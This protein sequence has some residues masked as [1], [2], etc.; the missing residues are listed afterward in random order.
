MFVKDETDDEDVCLDPLRCRLMRWVL[1]AA[2]TCLTQQSTSSW[3]AAAKRWCPMCVVHWNTK[4]LD[5]MEVTWEQ[6]RH[7]RRGITR[8]PLSF[9]WL[10]SSS[11]YSSRTWASDLGPYNTNHL[12]FQ[13]CRT[14]AQAD[15]HA[16]CM[17]YRFIR[18]STHTHT[19]RYATAVGKVQTQNATWLHTRRRI[20]NSARPPH[21]H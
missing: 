18:R 5:F 16:N 21:L 6:L 4:G 17:R 20:S 15:T 11:K 8:R 7:S 14:Y 9:S 13:R 10:I 12:L 19:L 2:R 3:L 1:T